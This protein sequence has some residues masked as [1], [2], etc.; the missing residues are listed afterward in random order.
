MAK[1]IAQERIEMMQDPSDGAK[2]L[3]LTEPKYLQLQLLL[4]DLYGDI[5]CEVRRDPTGVC[6]S[7]NAQ[8]F[9]ATII[10]LILHH[11]IRVSS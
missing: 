7:H 9:T 2:S 1:T 4:H 10:K 3:G 8:Q 11:N 6:S 5:I